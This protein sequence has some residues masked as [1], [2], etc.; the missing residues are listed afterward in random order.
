VKPSTERPRTAAITGAG[1]GL[2]REIAVKLAA[3]G[4]QVFDTA[5]HDDEVHDLSAAS[6]GRVSLSITDITQEGAVKVWVGQVADQLD[7]AG[8]DVLVSNAGILTPGPLEILPLQAI[9]REFDVNVFG[10]LAV[11]NAFCPR[12]ANR[13]VASWQSAQ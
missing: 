2:G 8:L 10:G 4:Y 7:E 6:D 11:I 9:K 13:E 1:S 3:K 12:C 5:L